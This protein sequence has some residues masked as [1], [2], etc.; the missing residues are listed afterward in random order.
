LAKR[1]SPLASDVT[2]PPSRL[3][4]G[5]HT[6]SPVV[7]VYVRKEEKRGG[8]ERRNGEGERRTEREKRKRERKRE[9]ERER[10]RE[11]RERRGRERRRNREI[12]EKRETE[13]ETER[14]RE[15]QRGSWADREARGSD[16]I[17]AGVALS[18]LSHLAARGSPVKRET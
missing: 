1:T 10:E 3:P 13:R 5:R 18:L 2:G 15:R 9:R 4:S 6:D 14:D 7:E 8:T 17:H 16:Q 11:G 12:R